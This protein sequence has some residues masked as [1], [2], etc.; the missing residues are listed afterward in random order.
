MLTNR[1]GEVNLDGEGRRLAATLVCLLDKGER[2]MSGIGWVCG[3]VTRQVEQ[4]ETVPW[5]EGAG[6]KGSS[7]DRRSRDSD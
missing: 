3:S 6:Y 1:L 7:I 4:S 2:R 5:S